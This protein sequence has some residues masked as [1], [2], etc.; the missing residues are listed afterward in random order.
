MSNQVYLDYNATAP[1]RPE[2][3]Q[4]MAD[5]LPEV[6]NPSSVHAFGRKA[7]ARLE[8]ARQQVANLV[9]VSADTVT[10]TGGG[11]EANNLA[12]FG[13]VD[14]Y[15]LDHILLTDVD[16]RSLSTVT[17]TAGIP[18]TKL[19]L[20]DDG[21]IELDALR[22]ALEDIEGRALFAVMLANNE[23]GVLQPVA[24][25]AELVHAHDGLLH[26]DAIQALGKI[27]VGFAAL[28]ADTMSLSSHKFGGPQGV[29]AL[30]LRPGIEIAPR[31][32]GGGQEMRRRSGTENV[33]GIAGLGAAADAASKGLPD[34]ERISKLRDKIEAAI[35][36]YAPET[37]IVGE[38]A[39]RLPNTSII[40]LP[41]VRSD[42]QVMSLDLA[43]YCVSSG[44]ACSSGKVGASRVLNGLGYGDKEAGSMIRV[45]LGWD[46][47]E[48]QVTGF[49]EAWKAMRDRLTHR[50]SSP[51][52]A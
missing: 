17:L 27:P 20:N 10:F 47:T 30:V 35:T 5:V 22:S 26:C 51:D 41:G 31:Q 14:F 24:E 49:I 46:T 18:V 36:A 45:S 19:P 40:I 12:L 21:L 44:S 15:K 7:K 6:G 38:G 23:S 33:A 11:T 32:V 43:G 52:V 9:G 28:G 25:M 34:Y 4:L 1:L 37:I 50:I 13:L 8:T 2:V 48:A 29:G 16:H 39:P 3:L 42:T